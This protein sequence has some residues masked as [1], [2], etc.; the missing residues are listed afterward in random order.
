MTTSCRPRGSRSH[1]SSRYGSDEAPCRATNSLALRLVLIPKSAMPRR[2]RGSSSL[3]TPVIKWIWYSPYPSPLPKS[4][5]GL[6]AS[7][8]NKAIAVALN[9][10][11]SAFR[12]SSFR[13]ASATPRVR[14]SGEPR[15]ATRES[16]SW[17]AP[18]A[19]A[20]TEQRASSAMTLATSPEVLWCMRLVEQVLD[21]DLAPHAHGSG[22]HPSVPTTEFGS[23]SALPPRSDY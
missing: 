5:S 14:Q 18:E 6:V 7:R 15:S 22:D 11:G 9:V 19:G 21:T 10:E 20:K 2:E 4:A 1:A 3:R 17:P 13:R 23:P 12:G 8:S 16:G